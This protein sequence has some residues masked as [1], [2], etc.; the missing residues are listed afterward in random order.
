MKFPPK[1]T[2]LSEDPLNI[3]CRDGEAR[4]SRATCAAPGTYSALPHSMGESDR[5][6]LSGIA[7]AL[8][9]TIVEP[10][11]LRDYDFMV[12]GLAAGFSH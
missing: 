7:A 3:P 2:E 4:S 8:G 9:R 12:I 10:Q 5:V 11:L 1:T 6:L